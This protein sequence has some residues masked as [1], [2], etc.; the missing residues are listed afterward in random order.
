MLHS[1]LIGSF[2]CDKFSQSL[3][4]F[5]ISAICDIL[6]NYNYYTLY[7]YIQL[8]LTGLPPHVHYTNTNM[9]M[10]PGQGSHWFIECPGLSI[11]LVVYLSDN[12]VSLFYTFPLVVY[13]TPTVC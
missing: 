13:S 4:F 2:M 1:H 11:L 6:Y 12:L 8:D 3:L 10:A 5:Y 7:I 9:G